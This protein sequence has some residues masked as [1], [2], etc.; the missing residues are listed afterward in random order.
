MN[1]PGNDA[2][3]FEIDPPAV[4]TSTGTEMAYPLS[5]TR[6][7]TGSLRLH[8]E[9]S[10]SKNS[11]SLVVPSPVVTST[12]S[13]PWNP[14]VMSSSR[15]RTDASAL[16]TA[17]RNCV[18]VGDD[19]ETM[20]LALCP[21]WLGIWRPPELGSSAAP[22]ASYSISLGVTPSCRQRARSR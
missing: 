13:S 6:Y 20:L 7:T 5:S 3:S 12:T 18:P 19:V 1:R 16:P 8:A 11:P 14:S 4:L 17:W 15:A 10:D 21:Q 9:L 22:T 2:T